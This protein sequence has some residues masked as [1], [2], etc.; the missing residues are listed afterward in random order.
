MKVLCKL[1]FW[2][3][4]L[5]FRVLSDLSQITEPVLF[6]ETV[7]FVAIWFP[8]CVY[9]LATAVYLFLLYCVLI[10]ECIMH[11][12]ILKCFFRGILLVSPWHLFHV[13]HSSPSV[14]QKSLLL[15]TSPHAHSLPCTLYHYGA[16]TNFV[17]TT[18]C[19]HKTF[20]FSLPIYFQ[21]SIHADCNNLKMSHL[22]SGFSLLDTC[23]SFLA[24]PCLLGS[25][26][27]PYCKQWTIHSNH[28]LLSA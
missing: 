20:Q 4:G 9:A 1:L 13:Y 25:S 14:L 28:H 5:A 22:S 24:L 15:L 21:L 12:G 23:F 2:C 11:G 8:G 17:V 16:S 3:R 26:F 6:A 27:N 7:W 18:P 19:S 10:S